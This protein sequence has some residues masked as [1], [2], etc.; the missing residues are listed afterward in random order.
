MKIFALKRKTEIDFLNGEI[1]PSLA[2]KIWRVGPVTCIV[3]L[4]K[5][6][7]QKQRR[8]SYAYS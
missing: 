2:K 4:V 1:G 6:Q 5:E 7:E 8:L 3:N